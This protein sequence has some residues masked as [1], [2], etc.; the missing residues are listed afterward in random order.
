MRFFFIRTQPIIKVYIFLM[1]YLLNMLL[2]KKIL[3]YLNNNDNGKTIDVTFIDDNY[4]ALNQVITDLN[5][6]NFVII[7]EYSARDFEAFGISNQRKRRLKAK[8]N[9][10]GK[11]YLHSLIEREKANNK[12]EIGGWKKYLLNSF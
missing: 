12:K 3:N 6:K 2:E 9:T 7:D 5:A 8:I 10:N 4:N 11:I 1:K